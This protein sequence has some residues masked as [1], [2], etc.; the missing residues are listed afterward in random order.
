MLLHGSLMHVTDS[1]SSGRFVRFLAEE[2]PA[3]HYFL[4]QPPDGIIMTAAVG[5]KV[6]VPD[7]ST[8]APLAGALWDGY[9]SLVKP[10]HGGSIG[11]F[12]QVHVKI[13][14]M[15]GLY[16]QFVLGQDFKDREGFCHR[17]K[18]TAAILHSKDHQAEIHEE[19]ERTAASEY[20]TR[21]G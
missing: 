19:L 6:I 7:L 14:N 10:L 3:A 5:W 20:W 17:M 13:R 8:I 1:L 16:D 4:A 2:A 21:V 9:H 12:P 15:K 18:E 11:R